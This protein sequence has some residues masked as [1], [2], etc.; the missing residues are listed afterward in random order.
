MYQ[1]RSCQ[2]K[3]MVH[4]CLT[5]ALLRGNQSHKQ[6]L[7]FAR[8]NQLFK[9]IHKPNYST[10]RNKIK[11]AYEILAITGKLL[12]CMMPRAILNETGL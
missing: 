8:A 10:Y 11:K 9:Q 3:P 4:S 5:G 7:I 12:I 1:A 2:W 6:R